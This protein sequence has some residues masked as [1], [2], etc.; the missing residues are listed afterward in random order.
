M[1]LPPRGGE[2]RKHPRTPLLTKVRLTAGEGG[3]SFEA[4]LTAAD[5]GLGGIFFQSE[6]AL[7]IGSLLTA[8]FELPESG[9]EVEASGPVVRVEQYDTRRGMGRS[10]FALRFEEFVGDGAVVLASIFLA[11]RVRDFV[12]RYLRRSQ[13]PKGRAQPERDQ[14]VDALVAW[15]IDRTLNED[16]I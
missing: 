6:F 11:P 2:K 3:R 10:G 8:H 13:R 7:K 12:D 16:E 15:E 14:L 9:R 5:V 1:S 4:T